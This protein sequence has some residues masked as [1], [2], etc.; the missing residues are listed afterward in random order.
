MRYRWR[1]AGE[2][3]NCGVK[4]TGENEVEGMKREKEG[5]EE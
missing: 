1:E 2:V 5:N 3:E 4:G